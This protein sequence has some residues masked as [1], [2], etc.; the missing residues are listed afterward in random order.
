MRVLFCN[1]AWMNFYKGIYPGIDEPVNGGSYVKKNRDANEKYNFLP[2]EIDFEDVSSDRYC[3]GFVET[4]AVFGRGKS[5]ELHIEKIE[6]CGACKKEPVVEDVLVIYCA[7]KPYQNFT[8]VVGWYKH[9]AVYRNYECIEIS[10]ED[11]SVEPLYYNAMAKAEDC[12]LLPKSERRISEWNVPRRQRGASYGFG[13]AN[14]WFAD[15]KTD[16][17]YQREFLKRIFEKFDAYKGE[18]WL[19]RFPGEQEEKEWL[20]RF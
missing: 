18:N 12:V 20:N 8:S 2:V 14:V 15:G 6:G 13:Q 11:G 19:D 7:A 17:P 1:I 10:F 16:N 9:A 5:N 3:L 4:K